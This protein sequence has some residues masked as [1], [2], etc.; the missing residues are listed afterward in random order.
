M[1]IERSNNDDG[2]PSS[3]KKK[4]DKKHDKTPVRNIMTYLHAITDIPCHLLLTQWSGTCR[5]THP[6]VGDLLAGAF[7]VRTNI[8]MA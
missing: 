7:H 5:R 8:Y 2:D 6:D 3:Y 1:I 4:R